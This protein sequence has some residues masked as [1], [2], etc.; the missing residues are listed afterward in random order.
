MAERARRPSP[1]KQRPAVA[2][3][4]TRKAFYSPAE[5]AQILAI[6]D[7]TVLQ[8]IHEG[9]LYA[10]RLGPRLFRIPLGSLMQFLGEPP[11]I[12]RTYRRGHVDSRTDRP[13]DA[14]EHER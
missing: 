7:Q 2:L 9:Q 8:R 13:Q 14:A 10:L 6:S 5:V 1:A 11:H 3:E 4:F 12:K